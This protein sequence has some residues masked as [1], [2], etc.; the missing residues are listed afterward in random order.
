MLLCTPWA[1]YGLPFLVEKA[2]LYFL[3]PQ[4]G[5][6]LTGKLCSTSWPQTLGTALASAPGILRLQ[7]FTTIP[8]FTLFFYVSVLGEDMRPVLPREGRTLKLQCVSLAD[9]YGRG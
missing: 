3:K 2:F 6:A 1:T 9:S 8:V 4:T 5:L 7:E